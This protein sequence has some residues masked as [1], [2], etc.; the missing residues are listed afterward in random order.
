M[1]LHGFIY[2]IKYIQLQFVDDFQ[3]LINDESFEFICWK[4]SYFSDTLH[5]KSKPI[6]NIVTT[7]LLQMGTFGNVHNI[8]GDIN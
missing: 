8:K 6:I 3:F 7:N 4:S 2:I 5:F 1:I